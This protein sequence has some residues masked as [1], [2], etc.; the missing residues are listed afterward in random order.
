M[1]SLPTRLGCD[2]VPSTRPVRLQCDGQGLFVRSIGTRTKDVVI[3]SSLFPLG[4]MSGELKLCAAPETAKSC[5]WKVGEWGKI[6]TIPMPLS[7]FG[8]CSTA[9]KLGRYWG[10][11]GGHPKIVLSVFEKNWPS[12]SFQSALLSSSAREDMG[13]LYSSSR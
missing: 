7:K 11:T 6:G 10:G 5:T 13:Q 12:F 3:R 8:S 1:L 9:L 2:K 4:E